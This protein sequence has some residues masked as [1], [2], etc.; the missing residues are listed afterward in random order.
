MRTSDKVG[1]MNQEDV[2]EKL[3]KD[4]RSLLI[5]SKMGLDP[6]Q[7][8]RDYFIMVGHPMPLKL[9]GFRSVMDMAR[10]LP[11]VVS[12]HTRPDSTQ[13]L[14]AV[15]GESTRTIEELVAKQR[16]P[17]KGKKV[18]T[19]GFSYFS[20]RYLHSSPSLVLPRRG[21]AP[22]SLP[23]QLRAQLRLLLSKGPLRVSDLEASFFR[24]F[25]HLLRVHS[26]GFYS[27]G[28]M[29]EAAADMIVIQQSRLGSVLILREHMIPRPLLCPASSPMSFGSIN[30]RSPRINKPA[31]KGPR[32]EVQTSTK[33]P[34]KVLVTSLN[35]PSTETTLGSDHNESTTVSD[36]TEMAKKIQ[37]ATPV[38][39]QD[40][41]LFHKRI[42]KLEEELRQQIL[43][44]GVAGTIS[45]ELKEK[46][47]KV[48]S[49]K[50]GG[51]SVHDLPSEY[52]RLFDEDLPLLQSG[53]VNVTELVGALSDIFHLKPAGGDNGHHWIIMN[54]QDSNSTQPES[55]E[56]ENFDD[57][58]KLQSTSYYLSG[59][60]SPWEGKLEEESDNITAEVADEEVEMSHITK[61]KEMSCDL[62]PA[63]QLH[64]S[65]TVPLDAL[66]SEHLKP[67]TRH[68]ARELVEVLVEQVES[69]GHFYIRFSGSEEAQAMEQMM[70]EMRRYYNCRD[71]SECYRL[72]E[73][74]VRRGQV[75]C[76]SPTGMWV[77]RVVIHQVI[78]PTQVE[79]YYVDFGVMT[80]VQS[81][82]LKFLKSAYSVLPAQAVPSS[83]TG[84]KPT[85]GIW[86]IEA[87]ASFQKLCSD[88]TLVGALDCYTGD[89]LQ[90]YLC[91]TN[92]ENDIYIHHVLLSQ[93]H[94]TA[95]SPAV[96][97]ALCVQITP[98]SLYLGTGMVDLPE[99][100]LEVISSPKP[101][102]NLKQ[103]ILAT[104]KV[105]DEELPALEY[106][107]ENE[108]IPHIQ[109]E[110]GNP[111]RALLNVQTPGSNEVGCVSTNEYPPTSSPCS[112]T[113]PLA[114]PDLIEMTR[115]HCKADVETVSMT[116]PPAP[117]SSNS[118]PCCPT[119][120]QVQQQPK[121]TTPPMVRPSQILRM[122]NLHTP[123]LAP[124]QDCFPGAP[125]YWRNSG[126][127]SPFFGSR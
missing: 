71:V 88:R 102:D 16:S 32:I 117:S 5:S 38:P 53:F 98:V 1:K 111:F 36:K 35:Q 74:F 39:C 90:L 125:V 114:P 120:E 99:V 7:L 21:S 116:P 85:T 57:G 18:G 93:G 86:T 87:T 77:Y 115:A 46:L 78:S 118:S 51:L 25:G 50:T 106:I 49:Q 34:A 56:T 22:P 80:V 43:E 70:M 41:Q 27:T 40:G 110:G 24:S 81:A 42:L 2:L 126:C 15:S 29:L 101:A 37:E 6:D 20:P 76:I 52:K 119:P 127:V 14:R 109:G 26:Y 59:G 4:V 89:V 19:G 113:S 13:Y 23:S 108:I 75:C 96:T 97:A 31:S 12:V 58:A 92:T 9:L 103:S 63:I 104:L 107:G 73:Q 91:D 60:E 3:K 48:V 94:G 61:T 54:I 105:E 82:N 121:V 122:L 17:K 44:N 123:D 30:P 65:P 84:I 55:K 95:C 72:P 79:V 11:D 68:A 45:Q 100:E 112:N 33:P 64:C 10:A 67:P 47:Q 124:T 62:Y 28:E 83:L 69:P 8:K 66:Q